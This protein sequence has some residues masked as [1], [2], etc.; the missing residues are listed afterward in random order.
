[1]IRIF[2]YIS[3]FFSH[4]AS[5]GS[6]EAELISLLQEAKEIVNANFDKTSS[7]YTAAL[8]GHKNGPPGCYPPGA[9]QLKNLLT[10]LFNEAG[11]ICDQVCADEGKAQS[12]NNITTKAQLRLLGI[13]GVMSAVKSF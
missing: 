10:P 4:P 9:L 8:I 13:D 5:A 3:L 7:C 11:V 2:F 6:C 1:M 12:C